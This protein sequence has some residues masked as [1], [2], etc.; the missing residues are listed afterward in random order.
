LDHK[1]KTSMTDVIHGYE[2]SVGAEMNAPNMEEIDW[3]QEQNYSLGLST[4]F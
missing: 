1:Y 2:W 4:S 3:K